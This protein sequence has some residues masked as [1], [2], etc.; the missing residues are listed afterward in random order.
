MHADD[1]AL[2]ISA[3]NEAALESKVVQVTK[4]SSHWFECNNLKMNLTKSFLMHIRTNHLTKNLWN[5]M[6]QE[7]VNDLTV[8]NDVKFL[9]V[10]LDCHLS[11]NKHVNELVLKLKK[12]IFLMKKLVNYYDFATLKTVYCCYFQS[13]LLYCISSWGSTCN[14]KVGKLFVAQKEIIRIMTKNPP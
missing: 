11:W 10:Y 13:K 3:E 7:S 14:G 4:L 9:G 12:D 6:L 5:L 2:V 8:L 1:C